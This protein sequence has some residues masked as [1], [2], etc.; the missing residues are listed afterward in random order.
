MAITQSPTLRLDEEPSGTGRRGDAATSTLTRARSVEG[1]VPSTRPVTVR[2][3]E[4]DTRTLSAPLT[5]CSL[6]RMW[7]SPSMTTPEPCAVW[8]PGAPGISRPSC[9]VSVV[10][11]MLTTPA[12]AAA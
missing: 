6:V 3:S 5:T 1:S 8:T 7:P 12:D 9:T 11:W 10:A 4:K 2:P